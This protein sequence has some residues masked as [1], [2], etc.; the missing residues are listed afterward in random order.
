M[1]LLMT[2]NQGDL[3]MEIEVWIGVDGLSIEYHIL[4]PAA[5]LS[6]VSL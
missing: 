5:F 2:G 6:T 1:K 4:S 3:R